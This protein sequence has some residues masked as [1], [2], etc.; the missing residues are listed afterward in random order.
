L[1][2]YKKINILKEV[3]GDYNNVG[4]E[5]LFFCPK[6]KHHK[7]KLSVNLSKDAFKCWIC[8]WHGKSIRRIVLRFG[9]YLQQ[10]AWNELV[11][12][13][14]IT[15]YEKLFSSIDTKQ[16]LEESVELP[17]EFISLC[18]K[19]V[20]LNS[21]EARRYLRDRG[22][23]KEDILFWKMGFAVSGEFEG[24]II[25][26]SF[27]D[28]G[29]LNYFIARRYDDKNWMRYKNP[30]VNK[31]IIFNELMID[32]NEDI[33]IVEGVFDAIK[34][35]NAIPLLGSTLRED[36]KL[37]KQLLKHDSAIYIALDSDAEKK[38]ERLIKSL[39]SY[40][41][42]VYKIDISGKKDV[43]EMTHEEFLERKSASTMIKDT[44]YLL[45]RKIMSL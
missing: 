29:K 31:D 10:K 15:D 1:S 30:K 45:I 33:T 4:S 35:K 12:I 32:W 11:G 16:E 28:M 17:S 19:D 5:M 8:D 3:L 42:E 22:I 7:R 37:F 2:D 23:T 20:S 34:A 36:S 38:A 27:N 13:V 21:L 41:A 43:G 44:D 24:R 40:D 18:N 39:M 9:N 14:E 25:V 26:P 6:C